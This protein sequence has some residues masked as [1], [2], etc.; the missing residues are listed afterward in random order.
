MVKLLLTTSML[1]L[2]GSL[3]AQDDIGRAVWADTTFKADDNVKEWPQPLRYYDTESKLFFAFAND[4]KNIYIC[5]QTNDDITQ[6]KI[7]GAG[8]SVSI[9]VKANGKHKATVNYPMG[10]QQ[11]TPVSPAENGLQK[12]FDR[13]NKRASFL[14]HNTMM[15]LKGFAGRDGLVPIHDSSG[16]NTSINWD[17]QNKMG[18]EV[19]IPFTA[20]YGNGYTQADLSKE[21]ALVVEVNALPKLGNGGSGGGFSGRGGHM[22]GGGG[23]MGGGRMGG[24]RTGDTERQRDE[25]DPSSQNNNTKSSLFEKTKLKEKFILAKK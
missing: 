24:G 25:T 3:L 21:I 2:T 20:F 10:S 7:L 14:M 23:R 22:G 18:Y 12:K 5:L 15:E 6:A 19:V 4:D 16:I 13:G 17:E 11:T 1:M 8:M 9:S